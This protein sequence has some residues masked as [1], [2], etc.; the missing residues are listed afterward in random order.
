MTVGIEIGELIDAIEHLTYQLLE[1][2]SRGIGEI[3]GQPLGQ[4]RSTLESKSTLYKGT[5]SIYSHLTSLKFQIGME[6]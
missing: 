2:D 6:S 1:E 5:E 4:S 3:Y